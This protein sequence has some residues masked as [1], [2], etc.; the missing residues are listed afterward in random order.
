MRVL[1]SGDVDNSELVG[2][3]TETAR[4]SWPLLKC[5]SDVR[6]SA[7]PLL[8]WRYVRDCTEYVAERGTQVVRTPWAF[9]REGV[10]DCKSTAV[11]IGSLSKAAGQ[12]VKMR[13]ACLPGSEYYGHVYA[14]I[15][16]V[17]YDPLL[18]VGA[19]CVALSRLDVPL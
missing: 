18:P 13:F 3:V 8:C 12:S 11:F 1:W 19:E 17:P 6:R 14:V 2:L 5:P 9:V 7:V 15:N 16:G 10:G 4:A